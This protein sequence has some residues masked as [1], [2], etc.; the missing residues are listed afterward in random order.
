MQRS[1]VC[2]YVCPHLQNWAK[3]EA[4]PCMVSSW[5]R[6]F[7]VFKMAF[8]WDFACLLRMFVA[9]F[10]RSFMR[11]FC[12]SCSCSASKSAFIMVICCKGFS[13]DNTA[14]KGQR[15]CFKATLL[16]FQGAVSCTFINPGQC[17]GLCGY[18]PYR[19]IVTCELWI[20]LLN[21]E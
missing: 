3:N 13:K 2:D 11:F 16:P 8:S 17:P 12:L 20:K 1:F 19:A 5:K 9:L 6:G 4:V 10:D 15:H 18:C 21:C 7:L 14:L